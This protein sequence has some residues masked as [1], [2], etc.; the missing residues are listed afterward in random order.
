MSRQRRLER[1]RIV[2]SDL[3]DQLLQNSFGKTFITVRRHHD[4]TR[5]ADDVLEIEGVEIGLDRHDRKP[6][7]GNA[8]A[9]GLVTGDVRW[10]A[11][12]VAA[13]AGYVDGA[14]RGC[15]RA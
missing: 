14:T 13:V 2:G 10:T 8:V 1:R 4:G 9:N 6:V 3:D 12:I 15:E 11:D 5:S 7:D